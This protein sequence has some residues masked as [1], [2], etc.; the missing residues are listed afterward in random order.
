MAS[1]IPDLNP[2]DFAIWSILE[3]KA[4]S[5]NHPNIGAIKNRLKACWDEISEETVPASCSQVPDR[6]SRVV[7]ANEGYIEN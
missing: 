1:F 6:L 2:V 7:K 4:C 5:S 3:S